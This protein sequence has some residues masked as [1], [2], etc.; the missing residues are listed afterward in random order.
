MEKKE[1]LFAAICKALNHYEK[2]GVTITDILSLP[3]IISHL[4]IDKDDSYM[5]EWEE[6]TVNLLVKGREANKA[7][8]VDIAYT[9]SNYRIGN[10]KFNLTYNSNDKSFT[11]EVNMILSISIF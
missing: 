5:E 11:A 3:D 1:K 8:E 4:P 9:E 7:K 2:D 6:V 10:A